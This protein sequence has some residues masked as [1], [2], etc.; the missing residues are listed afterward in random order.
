MIRLNLIGLASPTYQHGVVANTLIAGCFIDEGSCYRHIRSA[1][2]A[3]AVGADRLCTPRAFGVNFERLNISE[4]ESRGR[5]TSTAFN[6]AF[7]RNTL[8]ISG[9]LDFSVRVCGMPTQSGNFKQKHW[10]GTHRSHFKQES[11]GS[12]EAG[13]RDAEGNLARRVDREV[14]RRSG[15]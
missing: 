6:F 13:A 15:S 7:F 3:R 8:G 2:Q 10:S 14:E 9:L 1:G 4:G 12:T 5:Q 11:D